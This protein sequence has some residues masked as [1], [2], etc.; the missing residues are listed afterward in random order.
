M[1]ALPKGYLPIKTNGAT[2]T[3]MGRR[4]LSAEFEAYRPDRPPARLPRRQ[5]GRSGPPPI[6]EVRLE[7]NPELWS[8]RDTATFIASTQERTEIRIFQDFN[9][10]NYYDRSVEDTKLQITVSHNIWTHESKF[11]SLESTSQD[12]SHLAQFM[13]DDDVDGRSFMLLN[14]ATAQVNNLVRCVH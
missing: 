13:I 8:P 9:K 3:S 1:Q 11:Q 2:S 5:G 14:F 6:V 10:P 4:R 7:S 12:C